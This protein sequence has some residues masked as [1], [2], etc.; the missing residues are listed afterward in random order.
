MKNLLLLALPLSLALPTGTWTLGFEKFGG[1]QLGTQLTAGIAGAGLGYLYLQG[2]AAETLNSPAAGLSAG[3][4][5]AGISLGYT[6]GILFSGK[7]FQGRGNPFLT[8]VGNIVPFAGPL[9]AY[10]LSAGSAGFSESL[11]LFNLHSE[12]L[13]LGLPI[14]Y[15]K[16]G[17][18]DEPREAL[19]YINLVIINL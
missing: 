16:L 8:L 10:H 13:S 5:L 1:L 18:F 9:V 7:I 11:A 6:L 17:R 4:T 19:Y 2:S 14:P 15:R 12:K 3:Q